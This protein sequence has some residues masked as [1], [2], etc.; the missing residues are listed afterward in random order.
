VS[1]IT[2]TN[3]RW[4]ILTG[5]STGL[6][7]LML[8]STVVALALSS[9]RRD[10]GTSTAGLQWV[11]NVYLLAMAAFVVTLGRVGDIFGRKRIFQAGMLAFGVGSV[12]SATA[13]EPLQLIVGRAVQGVGAA[14][15]IA[16]SLAISTVAFPAEERPRALGIWAAVSSLALAIGPLVGGAVVEFASW[17]WIF[18]MNVPLVI[19]AFLVMAAATPET[20]DET[21]DRRLDVAGLLTVTLGLTALVLAL[22]QGKQWGWDSAGTLGVLAAGVVLLVAFWLVEHRVSQPIV[23]FELF[24]NGPY[25]GASAAAFALVGS[26]WVVM[27]F[28]PQYLELVL[29]Y[30]TLESGLLMLPVTAP[31]VAIS[32]F[33][34]R[35]TNRF[36]ARAL[37]TLGMACGAAATLVVTFVNGGSTYR[38]LLPGLLLFG[39]AL[40][41]VYAPMSAA[42]MAALPGDKAGIA[43]GVLAMTRTFAGALLLAVGGAL[44]QHIEVEQRADGES[45]DSAFSDA[46]AA[47]AWVLV[48]VLIAGTV[49]TA[50]FVRSAPSVHEPHHRRFHL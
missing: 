39:V 1:A 18:W 27:F 3:R 36:G 37:M 48:A 31:M 47:S 29:G 34:G 20:R 17:R 33:A 16:L 28:Q 44:F 42:A 32:P 5:A 45:F 24:R 2:E 11:Q 4:W 23:D 41:I 15:L 12:I 50:L 30:S 25:F 14:S 10:L 38:L 13:G 7:I 40:G 26:F 8:D 46:L 9:I 35:L 43:S 19:A 22:V 6:F 21:A 49:L